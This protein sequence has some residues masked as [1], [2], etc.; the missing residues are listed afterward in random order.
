M[1]QLKESLFRTICLAFST[2]ILT[3]FLLTTIDAAVERDRRG[4]LARELTELEEENERLRAQV[5]K[6]Y[7]PEKLEAYARERL[8]MQ[9]AG[10]G[11]IIYLPSPD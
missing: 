6:R 10:P 9:P 4:R 1:K 5:Q 2:L 3:V 8:G 7:S 11:Q